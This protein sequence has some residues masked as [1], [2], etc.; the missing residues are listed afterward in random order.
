M[1]VFAQ[2]LPTMIGKRPPVEAEVFERFAINVA[3]NLLVQEHKWMLVVV[4]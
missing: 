3:E 1:Q 4:D 2:H